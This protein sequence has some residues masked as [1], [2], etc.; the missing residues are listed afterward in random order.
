M[1]PLCVSLLGQGGDAF[2]ELNSAVQSITTR[3][4]VW[5]P[6]A[7]DERISEVDHELDKNRRLLAKID[8]RVT[9]PP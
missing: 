8:F 4:A 1:L 9:K 7:Y 6:G 5:S 2:A 3:F